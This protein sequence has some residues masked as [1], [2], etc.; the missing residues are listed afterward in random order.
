MGGDEGG[1]E[2]INSGSG[3][4]VTGFALLPA[5]RSSGAI[6]TL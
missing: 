4:E 3:P 6:S 2:D 5:V 1:G